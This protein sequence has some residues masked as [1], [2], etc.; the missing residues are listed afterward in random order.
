[1]FE[2]LTKNE[3]MSHSQSGFK[4][5]DSCINQLLCITHDIFQSLNDGLEARG[6]FL[7][8]SKAFNR[9]WHE[10]LLFKLKQ[11]AV[12]GNLLNVI[13]DFLNQRKQTVVLN[14]QHLPWTNVEA[15]VP[16][17]SI[18]K[19]LFFLIY[20][21]DSSDGLTSNPKLF[22]D[23]TSLF[24]VGQNIISTANNLNSDL[25]KISDWAFQWKMRFNL[26]PI[27]QAQ[28]VNVSRKINKS[29]HT[30]FDINQNLVKS[31]LAH[32]HLRMVLDTK[33]DFSLCLKNVQN[34]VNKTI[35]LH[36][37][38]QDTL[39]RIS[40][41]TIFKWFLRPHLD[42]D[43]AHNTSFHQDIKSIQYNAGLVITGAVRGTPREKL[44]QELGFESFQQR[45]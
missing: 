27:K 37:K 35:V 11:N 29:D 43:R 10:G 12:S 45:S 4:P 8:I 3:V 44:Y 5:G 16:Q 39:P 23:D 1:M 24:S 2:F 31:L 41:I 28:E 7:D 36:R 13:T 42:Y 14:G 38:L 30:P 19:P 6:I 25:M 9:V 33:L 22:A 32:K 15:G 40:L 26:D 20:I 17:G 21:N 34:K 18:L